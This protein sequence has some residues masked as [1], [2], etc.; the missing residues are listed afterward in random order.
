MFLKLGWLSVA[1]VFLSYFF[2]S[3]M[4]PT[5]FALGIFGLGDRAKRASAYIVI[6]H[7]RR[8]AAAQAH[9][10]HCRPFQH[11]ARLYRAD[12]LFYI[13]RPIR[14]LLVQTQQSGVIARHIGLRR[15]LT[16][17]T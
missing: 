6:G 11:V 10:G 14:I 12:D 2:M 5:I 16:P 1:C 9:G 17:N 4:F 13:H 3:I 7:C 8:R 15:S